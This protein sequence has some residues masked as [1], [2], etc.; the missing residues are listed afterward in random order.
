MRIQQEERAQEPVSLRTLSQ[1]VVYKLTSKAWP[2]NKPRN[3]KKSELNQQIAAKS[4]QKTEVIL[5]N[6]KLAISFAA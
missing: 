1:D 2:E 6:R 5:G 4:Q 3:S